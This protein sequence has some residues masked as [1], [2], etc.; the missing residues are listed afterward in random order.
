MRGIRRG[1]SCRSAHRGTKRGFAVANVQY[2]GRATYSKER[3]LWER[4][5]MVLCTYHC[6]NKSSKVDVVGLTLDTLG[7][8]LQVKA[9]LSRN[10][11]PPDKEFVDLDLPVFKL[12]IFNKGFNF[13]QSEDVSSTCSYMVGS[14]HHRRHDTHARHE[15]HVRFATRVGLSILI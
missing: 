14:E 5:A 7:R 8:G 3:Q 11:P 6:D 2:R 1:S 13:P 9:T 12:C 10:N 15:G 4:S